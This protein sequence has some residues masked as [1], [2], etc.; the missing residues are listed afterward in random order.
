MTAKIGISTQSAS[1]FL[2]LNKRLV[3]FFVS[4]KSL[5]GFGQIFHSNKAI[6]L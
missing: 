1:G 4:I 2:L 6:F 5:F 3:H